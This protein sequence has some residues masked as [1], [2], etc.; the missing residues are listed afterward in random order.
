MS[1]KIATDEKQGVEERAGDLRE[2]VTGRAGDWCAHD[3]GDGA[4]HVLFRAESGEELYARSSGTAVCGVA[5]DQYGVELVPRCGAW[6][7]WVVRVLKV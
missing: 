1:E 7:A 4:F 5:G 6:G 2:R 3:W